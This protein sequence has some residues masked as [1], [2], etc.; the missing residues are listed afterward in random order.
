MIIGIVGPLGSGKSLISD[1]FKELDF[2]YHSLSKTVREE[3]NLKNIKPLRKNFQK[4]GNLMRKEF[5]NNY[6]VLKTLEKTQFPNL[7]ID[8]IRHPG[9][10]EELKKQDDFILI[11]IDSPKKIRLARIKG[12]N[13][14]SDPKTFI[15][16]K[17]MEESELGIDQP[18]HGNQILKCLE[19]ADIVIQNNKNKEFALQQLEKFI[20][21]KNISF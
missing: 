9:E 18:E 7:I 1:Y 10:V 8:G 21:E 16:I 17:Q 12:R 2:E 15:E 3:A 20:K 11:G 13:R 19:M 4:L 14:Q 5:G 6:W